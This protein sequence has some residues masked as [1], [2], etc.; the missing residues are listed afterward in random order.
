VDPA[1]LLTSR[2]CVKAR[3]RA[4]MVRYR[5]RGRLYYLCGAKVYR[6]AFGEVFSTGAPEERRQWVS[7]F[8]KRIEVDPATGDILMHLFG[9][10][11]MLAPMQT[12]ASGETGV[13]IELAAGARHKAIQDAMGERLVRYLSLPRNG[14]RI[15]FSRRPL[16]E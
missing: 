7:L 15:S 3:C 8:M 9:R 2:R 11:A 4:N 12:P 5:N 10:P 6:G 1:T 16:P 14:R 13:R